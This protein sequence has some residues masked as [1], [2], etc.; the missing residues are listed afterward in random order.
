MDDR[1]FMFEQL[2]KVWAQI[3]CEPAAQYDSTGELAFCRNS[4]LYLRVKTL[5]RLC[6]LSG[7]A[8]VVGP[9]TFVLFWTMSPWLTVGATLFFVSMFVMQLLHYRLLRQGNIWEMSVTE[10]LDWY[11]R[12]TRS[13]CRIQLTGLSLGVPL[14]L[15]LVYM[16]V[17]NNEFL[18]VAGCAL[19]GLI[20]VVLAALVCRRLRRTLNEIHAELE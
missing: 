4:K 11:G 19:G 6:V 12:V 20:G 13:Y 18:V 2:R 14:V 16:L 1:D 3:D 7:G 10:A 15:W 9:L 8:C 5:K 17:R